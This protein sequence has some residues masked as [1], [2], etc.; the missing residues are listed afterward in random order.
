[1]RLHI[2]AEQSRAGRLT[3]LTKSLMSDLMLLVTFL[4]TSEL[5]LLT[6][7]GLPFY[8]EV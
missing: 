2:Q 8:P 7:Q 1:M 4:R 6:E 5:R 3:S